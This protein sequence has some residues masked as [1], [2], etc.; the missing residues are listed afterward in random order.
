MQGLN[1]LTWH[2]FNT[3][4]HE[5][6][7]HTKIKSMI[8][9][10]LQAQKSKTLLD[11]GSGSQPYRKFIENLGLKYTAHDFALY[12]TEQET[13][14]FGLHNS[15]MP[16]NSPEI[17]C[18]VLEIPEVSRFDL[19]LCTEVLEHVPD[20]V[21]LLEKAIK[22]ASPGGSIIFSVPG[23]SW[24]H[25]APFYFTAGL[26]PFW[27]EYHLAK[28]GAELVDGILIGNLKT[29][30]FQSM[31]SLESLRAKSV[32]RALGWLYRKIYLS[33][34]RKVADAGLFNA[35]ISQV[36]VLIKKGN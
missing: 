31:I 17:V 18:D 8:E 14:F 29:V 26:S 30:V 9:S 7:R 28:L 23:N 22:L 11:I 2:R 16:D 20:P 15:E 12:T 5:S 25:Q 32:L 6:F 35:P 21:A 27:F 24:T 10:V 3:Q 19:I 4:D 33:T 34:P 13:A 36:I 1:Y